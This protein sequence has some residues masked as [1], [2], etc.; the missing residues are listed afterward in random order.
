MIRT[1]FLSSLWMAVGLNLAL[2]QASAQTH[3]TVQRI[4]QLRTSLQDASIQHIFVIAHRGCTQRA[5]ENS[6]EAIQACIAMGVDMVELDV[7]QTRDGVLVLMHDERVDRT[8]NGSGRVGDLTYEEI[9]ALTLKVGFGGESAEQTQAHIPT[10][11]EAMQAAKG[12]ILINLDAKAD[13]YDAAFAV[14]QETDTQ[15]HI[16]M[17]KWMDPSEPLLSSLAPFD[18]VLAMPIL[19]QE[20]GNVSDFFAHITARPVAIEYIFDDLDFSI[21]GVEAAR[22]AHVRAWV[23]SLSGW[24]SAGLGDA[25]AL[26]DPDTVWGLFIDQGYTMIQTDHPDVLMTYLAA[27]CREDQH[28]CRQDL[29]QP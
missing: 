8:T 5:P 19:S 17:K 6:I 27:R 4:E 11:K 16:L 2:N 26:S 9:S 21:Q 7:R 22:T 1:S 28:Y 13:V 23:N 20:V 25:G 29:S 24:T 3:E 15:D 14:L 18:Q 10:F 12:R